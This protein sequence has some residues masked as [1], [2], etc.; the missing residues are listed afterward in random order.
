M[1]RRSPL[2]NHAEAALV[3]ALLA[4]LRASRDP[5]RAARAALTLLDL[6]VP[7]L[8]A[9][10]WRNFEIAMPELPRGERARLLEGCWTNLARVLAMV[11]QFPRIHAGNVGRF[12]RYEGLENYQRA[13]A[14]GRGV[15]VATAHLGNWEFSAFAHALMTEPMAVVVRPLDNPL[16]DALATRYRTL[17]GNRILGRGQH[18]LR[19]LL[20]TLHAGGAV[21]ILVDQNVTADRGVFVDFFGRKACVDSGL[22][23]LAHRTGAAVLLGY[24]LWSGAEQRYV[25]HFEPEIPISGDAL[26]DTQAVHARLEAAIRRAPDQWLWIHRR[27]KTRPPGEPPLY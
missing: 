2:R 22:A 5:V 17:S 4:W 9:A 8:R 16:L 10:A 1:A 7:R 24:A 20:E 13:R 26:A 3:K 15:L 18:F 23:R 19:P 11:A 27:W 6:A 12:I 14:R 25:L 21:G